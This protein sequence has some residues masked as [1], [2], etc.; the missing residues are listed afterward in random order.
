MSTDTS[1]ITVVAAPPID[2]LKELRRQNS[3]LLQR[4]VAGEG[5][6]K[7]TAG[8]LLGFLESASK[9]G[10]SLEDLDERETAQGIMDV[11]I[12]ALLNLDPDAGNGTRPFTLEDLD[13]SSAQLVANEARQLRVEAVQAVRRADEILPSTQQAD[14]K[15]IKVSMIHDWVPRCLKPYAM[16]FAGRD[17]EAS[18]MQRLLM[19]FI[20]LK[21]KST[22]AYAVQLTDEDKIFH[23]PKAQGVL[24][25]LIKAGVVRPQATSEGPVRSFVL[26]HDTLL[27]QWPLLVEII[28]QRKAFRE[29][30]RGWDNGGRQHAALLSSGEQLL[31]A[32]DYPQLDELE[33]E[34]VERSRRAG[35]TFRNLILLVAFIIMIVLGCMVWRLWKKNEQLKVSLAAEANAIA[36]LAAK[37]AELRTANE[38]IQQKAA[39]ASVSQSKLYSLRDLILSPKDGN[40]APKLAADWMWPEAAAFSINPARA[41]RIHSILTGIAP[42]EPTP[43]Y[44]QMEFFVPL[45]TSEAAFNKALEKQIA[46]MASPPV[47]GEHVFEFPATTPLPRLSVPSRVSEVRYFHAT[48]DQSQD[49]YAPLAKEVMARLIAAGFTKPIKLAPNKDS[50]APRFFIQVAFAPSAFD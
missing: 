9:L 27:T 29:L 44:P 10:R 7:P 36:E 6:S 3:A 48:G 2:S 49:A 14:V 45:T 19:R 5:T 4:S 38:D 13:E 34:F 41:E 1:P 31:Q 20:R 26:T 25:Q 43:G 8:E 47:P 39:L 28:T 22:E 17:S 50:T 33:K 30:A 12:A 35:E 18:V 42:H 15:Q 23:E 16:K 46:F 40:R 21:E 24:D 11:W 32:A 37:N